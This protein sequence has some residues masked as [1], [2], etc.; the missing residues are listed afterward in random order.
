MAG[1]PFEHSD[2]LPSDFRGRLA[3]RAIP[4][5]GSVQGGNYVQ[6]EHCWVYIRI[7]RKILNQCLEDGFI[8]VSLRG[9]L[10]SHACKNHRED[11]RDHTNE[12]TVAVQCLAMG[13]CR[14]LETIPRVGDV[15]YGIA[16][17]TNHQID[18]RSVHRDEQRLL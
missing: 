3:P 2:E 14:R 9:H 7:Q 10:A 6:T 4:E 8:N 5:F 15:L 13:G 17:R 1:W 12:W 11:R 16:H 18:G